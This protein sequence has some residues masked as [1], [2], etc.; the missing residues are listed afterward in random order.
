MTIDISALR[1]DLLNYFGTAA[2]SGM[3]MALFD[4]SKVKNASPEELQEI[5]QKNGFDLG[6]YALD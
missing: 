1:K 6:K 3:P 4:L 2:F 5:A